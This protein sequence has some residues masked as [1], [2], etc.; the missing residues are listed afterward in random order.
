MA[1]KI[2]FIGAGKMAEALITAILNS[3]ITKEIITSDINTNRLNYLK[4]E[5]KIKTTND[6]KEILN[7][8]IIFLAVKPQ[9]M[10][11][12]LEEIEDTDKL[13]VSIAAGITI[14][15]LES[16]LKNARVIRVMPNTPCLVGEMAAGFSLGKKVKD[17]DVKLIEELLNSAGK[18]YLL[19]EKLLDGV[20]GLS[21]S[22]PAFVAYLLEGMIEA[23]VKEGLNKDIATELALQTFKGTAKLLQET[24]ISPLELIDMVSSPGGTTVEGMS[25]LK[26]SDVK[27]VLRETIKA[28]AKRS[29][30]LKK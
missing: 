17:D 30:E 15:H 12:V 18:A 21:G 29:K 20:T 3:K 28:A 26:K 16:K 25:V 7:S 27:S 2:G 6:N 14:G 23:G 19:N 5:L 4:K 1:C 9:V 13:V 24:G 10:D 8:D 22:G 11:N